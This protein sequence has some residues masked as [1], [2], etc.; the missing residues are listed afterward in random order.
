MLP[1]EVA[2]IIIG[3]LGEFTALACIAFQVRQTNRDA[4]YVADLQA[5]V[6]LLTDRT[7]TA[8][9]DIKALLEK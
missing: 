5:A 6:L 7:D 8:V 2:L 4:Q 1:I 3:F 9:A